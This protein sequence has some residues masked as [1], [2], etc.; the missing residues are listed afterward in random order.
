MPDTCAGWEAGHEPA[1][2]CHEIHTGCELRVTA[3]TRSIIVLR[4]SL[5]MLMRQASLEGYAG[6]QG[7]IPH[8]QT[9]SLEQGIFPRCHSMRSFEGHVQYQQASADGFPLSG[10]G[11]RHKTDVPLREASAPAP[12]YPAASFGST[13]SKRS[14]GIQ[15]FTLL[16]S[17]TQ[18]HPL[19]I[20]S[21]STLSPT[22]SSSSLDE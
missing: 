7:D 10:A 22:S 1:S 15:P 19:S 8:K 5:G 9:Y 6:E 2:G 12:C 21:S 16:L 18:A 4:C 20:S 3:L 14:I 17:S 11:N 13:G